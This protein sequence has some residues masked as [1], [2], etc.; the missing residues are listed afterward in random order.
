MFLV[1][2]NSEVITLVI[3]IGSSSVGAALVS[4]VKKASPKMLFSTRLP[5]VLTNNSERGHS[6]SAIV[7]ALDNVIKLVAA[8]H[9]VFHKSH[10]IFS[11][12]WYV[13][14]T[15]VLKKDFER[16]TLITN[17]VVAQI[18]KEIEN[19]FTEGSAL[20]GEI[21][22]RRVVRAKLNGYEVA[23]PYNKKA[24]SLEIAHFASIVPTDAL[25]SI[26]SVIGKYF[27]TLNNEISSFSLAAY[28]TISGLKSEDKDFLIVDVRGEVTDVTLVTDGVLTKSLFFMQG[29]N[30]LV[31]T[32]ADNSSHTPT[33]A[34]SLITTTLNNN[35]VASAKTDTLKFSGNFKQVWLES[36]AKTLQD[37]S[38]SGAIPQTVYLF[39]DPDVEIFFENTLNEVKKDVG[40]YAL[41]HLNVKNYIQTPSILTDE[42]LALESIFVTIV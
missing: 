7:S 33:A 2:K 11:S 6:L 38:E 18:T 10:I 35:S 23:N 22:E 25:N 12:P 28:L 1:K 37:L 5:I 41:K 14:Q 9:I 4:S 24:K 30:E 36:Y 16:P 27:H 20:K 13:S 3:D 26:K 40:V 31:N 32:V 34:L 17:D 21:V 15:N 19:K 39:A 29:K 42:F 8:Q